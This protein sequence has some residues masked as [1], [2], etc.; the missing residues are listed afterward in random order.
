M[1]VVPIDDSNFVDDI[2][3]ENA[4]AVTLKGMNK[5]VCFALCLGAQNV[6]FLP[7]S[8]MCQLS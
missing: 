6:L 5:T 7:F 4:V 8:L 1:I 2:G 3:M